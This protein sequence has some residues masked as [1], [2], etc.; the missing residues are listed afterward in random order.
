MVLKAYAVET[1]VP[2]SVTNNYAVL[3]D[4]K[5]YLTD[6]GLEWLIHGFKKHSFTFLRST[7][8]FVFSNAKEEDVGDLEYL[9]YN[10]FRGV[11]GDKPK[12]GTKQKSILLHSHCGKVTEY[13][14]DTLHEGRAEVLQL[15]RFYPIEEFVLYRI[16][17]L[18][19]KGKAT[20]YREKVRLILPPTKRGVKSNLP[21]IRR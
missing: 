18:T 14:F 3:S 15:T 20:Y 5:L 7:Y 10:N 4:Y 2:Y 9:G 8:Q 13:K 1:N 21:H 12:A 11:T 6:G 19:K 16:R 17:K